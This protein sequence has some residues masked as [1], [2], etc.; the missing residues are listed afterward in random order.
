MQVLACQILFDEFIHCNRQAEKTQ[1]HHRR[2]T[3][4]SCRPADGLINIFHVQ[5]LMHEGPLSKVFESQER[6]HMLDYKASLPDITEISIC[7]G[8]NII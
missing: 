8:N 7:I 4:T 1:C 6:H 5:N 3:F 2:H